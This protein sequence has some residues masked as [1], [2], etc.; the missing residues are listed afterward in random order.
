MRVLE[1]GGV[2]LEEE[3][4]VVGRMAIIETGRGEALVVLREEVDGNAREGGGGR[5]GIWSPGTP[6]LGGY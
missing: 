5:R 3:F 1:R 4:G 2:E 6:F